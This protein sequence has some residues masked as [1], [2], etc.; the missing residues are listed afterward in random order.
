[1]VKHPLPVRWD[2]FAFLQLQS[3]VD[4]IRLE[5]PGGATRVSAKILSAIKELRDNPGKYPPDKLRQDKDKN[6]R[7]FE[8]YHYRITYYIAKDHI[9]II[10]VRHT[11]REPLIH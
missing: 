6:F 1:M 5:S 7:A 3:I 4:Y 2:S 10:R 9:R 8:V 11:G